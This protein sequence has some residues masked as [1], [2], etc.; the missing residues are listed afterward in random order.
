MTAREYYIKELQEQG[1]SDE[2]IRESLDWFDE[3]MPTI[4]SFAEKYALYKVANF[5]KDNK[6]KRLK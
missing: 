5:I 3:E 4:F 2:D 6:G 1:I